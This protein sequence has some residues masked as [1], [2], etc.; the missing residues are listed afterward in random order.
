MR[1]PGSLSHFTIPISGAKSYPFRV[2][3]QEIR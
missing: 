3:G 2:K 1:G